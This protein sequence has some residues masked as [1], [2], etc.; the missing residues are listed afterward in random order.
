M[1][2]FKF[3]REKDRQR[4]RRRGYIAD[5]LDVAASAVSE[6]GSEIEVATE[7]PQPRPWRG[8]IAGNALYLKVWCN[9]QNTRERQWAALRPSGTGLS[10]RV[11]TEFSLFF[12]RLA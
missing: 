9:E 5:N 3:W 10:R 11:L 2:G 12:K 8:A 7:A 1:I 4:L 6:G